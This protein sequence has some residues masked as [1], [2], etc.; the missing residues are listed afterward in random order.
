MTAEV[1]PD[2]RDVGQALHGGVE[3]AR[4]ERGRGHN[5]QTRRKYVGESQTG[6]HERDASEIRNGASEGEAGE[7]RGRSRAFGQG[8]GRAIC[9]RDK[10]ARW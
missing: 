10:A 5:C 3:E 9:E 7:A 6:K 8:S 2:L 4:A 1:S